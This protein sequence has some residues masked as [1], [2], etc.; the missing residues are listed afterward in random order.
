VGDNYY[1]ASETEMQGWWSPLPR[2]R[3]CFGLCLFVD[4]ISWKVVDK[5]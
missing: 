5:S 4:G 1:I 2:R 3:I